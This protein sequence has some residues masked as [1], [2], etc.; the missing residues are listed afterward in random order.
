MNHVG[1]LKLRWG[2]N[3]A[4]REGAVNLRRG[5]CRAPSVLGDD[6]MEELMHGAAMEFA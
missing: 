4:P 3:E 1:S 6:C 5:F 2:C